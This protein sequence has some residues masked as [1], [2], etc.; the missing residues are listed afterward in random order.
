MPLRIGGATGDLGR[1]FRAPMTP[2]ISAAGEFG[3]AKGPAVWFGNANRGRLRLVYPR[4]DGRFGR[5][6]PA[7]TEGGLA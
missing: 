1:T 4:K 2:A 7:L 5:L 3:L 6:G